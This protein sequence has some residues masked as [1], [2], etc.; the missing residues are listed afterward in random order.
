VTITFA[1]NHDLHPG[2]PSVLRDRL[3]TARALGFRLLPVPRVDISLSNEFRSD[4]D[5]YE[6]AASASIDYNERFGTAAAEIESR[7]A[8]GAVLAEIAQRIGARLAPAERRLCTGLLSHAKDDAKRSEIIKAVAE[9]ADGDLVARSATIFS[10]QRTSEGLRLNSP[11]LVRLIVPGSQLLMVFN[12]STH[13]SWP[14][15]LPVDSP[16]YRRPRI[17]I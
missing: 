5:F 12:S 6:A 7:G 2:L 15:F 4:Q 16:V 9:W 14:Q 17:R 11:F 10:A 8:G 13:R 3:Q 1:T